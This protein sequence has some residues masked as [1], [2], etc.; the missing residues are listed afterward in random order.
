MLQPEDKAIMIKGTSSGLTFY[1]HETATF[2]HLCEQLVTIVQTASDTNK[3]EIVNVTVHQGHRYLQVDE[4]EQ[5]RHIIEKN[6]NF[7]IKE[8]VSEVM[9][10]QEA[11]ALFDQTETKTYVQIVRSGQVLDITGNLLLIGD[12]NPGGEVRATGNIYILGKL[13]GV[14]HAGYQGDHAKVIIASYMNPHQLRIANYVSR[15]P[16][17]ETDGVYMECGYYDEEKQQILIDS[18]QTLRHIIGKSERGIP[19]G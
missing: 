4:Q 9:S 1:L 2:H 16:D 3:E 8:F 13:Y 10:K 11:L 12:V 6:G 7:A 14:A 18:L 17:N 15:S 19:N 5:I